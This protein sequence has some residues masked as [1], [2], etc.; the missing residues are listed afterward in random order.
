[1][2]MSNAVNGQDLATAAL[3]LSEAGR[4]AISWVSDPE[5]GRL[6]GNARSSIERDLRRAVLQ[7]KRLREAAGRPMA[8]AVFGASQVGKSHL[9]SVLARKGDSLLADFTG[10]PEP[11]NYIRT[12]NPDKGKEATGL[13]SRFTI[14]KRQTPPGFPVCLRL[15]SHPDVIKILAN[16]YI[17]EGNPQ[18]FEEWP[19]AGR[20]EE[21][22]ASFRAENGP[23][24]SNGLTADDIWD[25]AEYFNRYLGGSEL[26]KRLDGF[27]EVAAQVAPRLSLE[28]LGS[29]M[30]LLWGRHEAI[31]ELYLDLIRSLARLNFAGEAFVPFEAIDATQ[32]DVQSILDVE[33][34][35]ALGR[36]DAPTLMVATEKG[37]AV[38][39]QRAVVAA[40]TAEL[41]IVLMEKPWDFFEHTDLLDFPGYRGRGLPKTHDDEDG[42]KGLARHFAT[43]RA[44][45]LQEMILRGKVEYLFQRYVAEQEITSMLL[46]VKESNMEPKTLLTDVVSAWVATTHGSRPQDRANKNISLFFIFTRFDTHFEVKESDRTMGLEQRF[47][48]RVKVSLVDAFGQL[49][50]SWPQQWESGRPFTNTFLMRNPNIKNDSIFSFDSEGYRETA[51][52]PDR[53]ERV[54]QLRAAFMASELVQRHFRNPGQSFDEMMRLNDGGASHIA[55][56]LARVCNPATKATQVRNGLL[57]LRDRLTQKLRDFHIPTDVDSRLAERTAYADRILDE[58]YR[59]DEMGRFGSF[60]R[61][62]TID[63]GSFADRFHHA[64]TWREQPT[65]AMAARSTPAVQ[66]DRPR[67]GMAG[68]PNRPRPGQ[69]PVAVQAMVQEESGT[70]Q[71]APRAREMLLAETAIQYWIDTLYGRLENDTLCHD[72]AVSGEVMRELVRELDG[73]ARRLELKQ[74]LAERFSEYS[75]EE[76]PGALIVKAAVIAERCLNQFVSDLGWSAVPI[77]D[78]PK[79][80]Y[81]DGTSQPIF[82]PRPVSFDPADMPSEPLSF[83]QTYFLD[84]VFGFYQ[85]VQDNAKSENGQTINVAQNAKIGGVLNTLAGVLAE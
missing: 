16:S 34:L 4:D 70:R 41:R 69:S 77:E 81:A 79:A 63:S 20:I 24:G 58:L 28:R 27:W 61:G 19:D 59:C 75:H 85:L 66:P 25:L 35:S 42:Q 64:L 3:R 37:P 32:R 44:K 12:I 11:V 38:E 39:L 47:E 51:I 57:M 43:N 83:R 30:S 18:E 71:A 9:I 48:G 82:A 7:G 80:N 49:P 54:K 13:V 26:T 53:E 5:N 68:N 74:R 31:T 67:P 55:D 73:A 84:W 10:L 65:A 72:I 76:R 78:R 21:H 8:V 2:M 36:E 56:S 50:D 46:C 45:T 40:L 23:E 62:L 60:L 6:V 15:L 1:M 14:T 52:R 22:L 17:F 33:V 29:L